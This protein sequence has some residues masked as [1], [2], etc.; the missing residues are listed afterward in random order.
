MYRRHEAVL[1]SQIE[2]TQSSLDDILQFEVDAR[3][4][5][6]QDV[7]EVVNYVRAMNYG[8]G[9]LRELLLCLRLIRELHATLLEGVRGAERTPG[10]FRRS[11]N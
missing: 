11:Q 5:Y 8:L 6:P 2:G 1:S 4:A 9:R 3:G 10:E 7:E